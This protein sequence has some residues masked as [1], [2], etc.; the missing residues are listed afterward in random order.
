MSDHVVAALD[1]RIVAWEESPTGD[2]VI[3]KRF[4][5]QHEVEMKEEKRAAFLRLSWIEIK[6][7][8]EDLI[9][10]MKDMKGNPINHDHNS[11]STTDRKSN[12]R[13]STVPRGGQEG[14]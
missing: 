1:N 12:G 10:N 3:I 7:L 14:R 9:E 13:A 6:A 2:Y 11:T 4:L 5:T 8:I